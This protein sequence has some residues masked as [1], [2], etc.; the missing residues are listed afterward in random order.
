MMLY[1]ILQHFKFGGRPT[2][3]CWLRGRSLLSLLSLSGCL[4]IFVTF[5]LVNGFPFIF[6]CFC[7]CEYLLIISILLYL[8]RWRHTSAVHTVQSADGR[9]EESWQRPRSGTHEIHADERLSSYRVRTS[10]PISTNIRLMKALV[11]PVPTY[12]CESCTLRKNEETRYDAYEMKGL[13]KILRVSW[14]A[15][16]TNEWVFSKPGS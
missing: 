8:L 3:L 7:V 13:R 6:Q 5:Y 16:K 11:W 4:V 2:W 15:K 9:R 10:L 14:R 12:G 1:I